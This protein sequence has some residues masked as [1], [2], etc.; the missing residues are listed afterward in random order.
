MDFEDGELSFRIALPTAD[1]TVSMSQYRYCMAAS[2]LIIGR[3][4]P[5]FLRIIF[6][7]ADPSE[8]NQPRDSEDR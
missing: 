1:G 8:V 4:M 6:G 7:G 3:F 5:A 2:V